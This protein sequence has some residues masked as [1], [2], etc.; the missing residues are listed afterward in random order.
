MIGCACTGDADDLVPCEEGTVR[1]PKPSLCSSNDIQKQIV[2]EVPRML[3]RSVGID[4]D[5]LQQQPVVVQANVYWIRG[6]SYDSQGRIQK[7]ICCKELSWQQKFVKDMLGVYHVGIQVHGVEYTF[8]NYHAPD[9]R[10]LGGDES[11]VCAHVP[12]NAG[13][14]LEFRESIPLGETRLALSQVEGCA[15]F[16]GKQDFQRAAYNRIQKNCVDFCQ[17]MAGK[18][19]ASELP[20]WCYRGLAAARMMQRQF[21]F[22]SMQTATTPTSP[23]PSATKLVGPTAATL[24]GLTRQL[25]GLHDLN[26]NGVLEEDELIKLNEKIAMLHYG[27]GIDKAA[28]RAK[29]SDLFRRKLDKAGRPVPYETF[30]DYMVK[31]LAEIDRDP[32]AQE[33]I[34]EQWIAEAECARTVFHCRSFQS[35]SDEAF[36][37]NIPFSEDM[38]FGAPSEDTRTG[39]KPSRLNAHPCELP[40][41]PEA[42]AYHYLEPL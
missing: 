6:M 35:M 10:F 14:H 11:G 32:A 38:V 42:E 15:G 25:F 13:I 7:S 5:F 40:S 23:G 21:G 24:E 2:V 37:S 4:E 33:M 31:I 29:Y 3:P 28:I 36:I 18:L 22:R 41:L 20:L 16:L 34:L 27:K 30:R 8:G 9:G 17:K 12:G 19:A 39:S 26:A 1:V